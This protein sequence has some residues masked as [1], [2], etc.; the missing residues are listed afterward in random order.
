MLKKS[1]HGPFS[2]EKA[3][4]FAIFRGKLLDLCKNRRLAKFWK[5]NTK[6]SFREKYKVIVCRQ[7][8]CHKGFCLSSLCTQ[9]VLQKFTLL[10]WGWWFRVGVMLMLRTV[11]RRMGGV[12]KAVGIAARLVTRSSDKNQGRRDA[13]KC[14]IEYQTFDFYTWECGGHGVIFKC[15]R[16]H[17]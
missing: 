6:C 17:F 7:C 16:C 3:P 5:G 11:V 4:M 13:T 9:A 14:R 15:C 2:M 1:K 10:Q 8:N 12:V